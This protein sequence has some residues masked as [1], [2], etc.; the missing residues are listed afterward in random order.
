MAQKPNK[1]ENLREEKN[2]HSA[3][4]N[5]AMKFLVAGCAGEASRRFFYFLVL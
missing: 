5:S 3:A 4:V 2:D 1:K